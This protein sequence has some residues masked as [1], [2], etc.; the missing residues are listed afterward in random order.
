MILWLFLLVSNFHRWV[1][2][3]SVPSCSCPCSILS[4]VITN[5]IWI[6]NLLTHH[7]HYKHITRSCREIC[8]LSSPIG[9]ASRAR[10]RWHSW[11]IRCNMPHI[12]SNSIAGNHIRT[13]LKRITRSVYVH[14]YFLGLSLSLFG[15]CRAL[16]S[17][18]EFFSRNFIKIFIFFV[19][20]CW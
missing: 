12:Q 13:R 3:C 17:W 10:S 16:Q 20:E 18:I 6:K 2:E 4:V 19:V 5:L 7:I 9:T 14:I 1:G 15:T 8:S 11:K